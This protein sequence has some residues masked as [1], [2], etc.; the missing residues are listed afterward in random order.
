MMQ[1]KM[2][3]YFSWLD[4]N[5]SYYD[6]ITHNTM[7]MHTCSQT[8]EQGYIKQQIAPLKSHSFQDQKPIST[9]MNQKQFPKHNILLVAFTALLA[10]PALLQIATAQSLQPGDS[11]PS[12]VPESDARASGSNCLNP[13]TQGTSR[14]SEIFVER[15]LSR[16]SS[17]MLMHILCKF[18]M[19]IPL[20]HIVQISSGN[21]IT[22]SCNRIEL[23]L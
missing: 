7:Y 2:E 18:S 16:F 9:K 6:N 5:S 15:W 12:G 19:N 1:R 13:I 4:T 21:S 17:H 23:V 8:N 20:N 11:V 10:T 14:F 22:C 3:Q